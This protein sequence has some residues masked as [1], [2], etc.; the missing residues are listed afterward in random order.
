M[1][2]LTSCVGKLFHQIV[3][4]RIESYLIANGLLDPQT[5]KAFL[6]GINGCIEH[7]IVMKE[8]IAHAK[9]KKHTLHVTFFD[10]ADAFGSVEHNLIDKTLRKNNVP[11]TVCDYVQCLY[12]RLNS[13][14]KTKQWS[15]EPF[16]F[17]RGV[18]Q[19]D[20]LSP[21]IFLM[22]FNPILQNLKQKES[23]AGYNLDGVKYITLP[24]A[25]DFCLITSNKRRHQK[26][27]NEINNLACSMNLTLKP[28]KCKSISIRSGKPAEISFN[29]G[30]NVLN[31]LK[32]APEKFLGCQITFNGKTK[33]IF[34]LMSTKLSEYITNI[35]NS[36]IRNE[37]KLRV[38]VQYVLPSLR[39]LMTVHEITDTQLQSLDHLHTNVIKSYL[40]M[41]PRGPTPAIIHSPYGL[42]I[43]K[44]SDIYVESHS[45]AY[46]RCMMKADDRVLHAI[47]SKASRE[48]LWKR[49]MAKNGIAKWKENF[50]IAIKSCANKAQTKWRNVKEHIKSLLT[51]QRK[52][53]W[54]DYV[55]PLIQQGNMLKL[56]ESEQSDLTWRSIIYDMP[57][58]VMSFAVRASIDFLPTFNNLSTW[59]KRTNTK[60]N[61]CNNKET[62]HHILN[63]CTTFLTQGR[64][65]WRHNSILS[66]IVNH[67]KNKLPDD[68]AIKIYADIP[69]WL[70]NGSTVPPNILPT[71][72]RPDLVI[73]DSGRKRIHVV[74]LT[75]PFER[76]IASA[77]NRKTERYSSLVSDLNST[78]YKCVL[79]CIEIGSRGFISQDNKNRLCAIFKS[80]GSK[81]ACK[82][83]FY[84]IS[85]T[86]LL[87]S[88]AIWNARHEPSWVECPYL[89]I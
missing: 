58:G 19:G 60:C 26:I 6:K 32:V 56:I 37:Y 73:V 69:G 22:V 47:R 51:T 14:I 76:N 54:T 86:T 67:L 71:S 64:Y 28:S 87:C 66:T 50:D 81:K 13:K 79:S 18:F 70:I 11:G 61:F 7:T 77:N 38:Y 46:A 48:C 83:L 44:L 80:V 40:D 62:L 29:I 36:A 35:D 42:C 72:Q 23:D 16:K 33:D 31:T 5:Q 52:E 17:K 84:D 41:Q 3:A 30:E 75:I 25:D 10:L 57:R 63:N 88:Y 24:F 34:E 20:P 53:F 27:M 55:L 39:Y 82:K 59:G 9:A 65:T 74:E 49:K 78:E 12:S 89:K 1:I 15:S 45:L 21:I 4:D 68:A 8:I 85:K 2:S 43:P